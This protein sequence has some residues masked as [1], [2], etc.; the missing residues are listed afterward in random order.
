MRIIGAMFAGLLALLLIWGGILSSQG[1][2]AAD[3]PNPWFD[4]QRYDGTMTQAEFDAAA[5]LFD[6][7]DALAPLTQS[8][9]EALILYPSRTERR[10]P[11]FQ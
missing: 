9:D 10:V 6:P 8:D 1:E 5:D 2:E 11:Q 4:L 3:T 7:S